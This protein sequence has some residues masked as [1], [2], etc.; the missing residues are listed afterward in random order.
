[1]RLEVGLLTAAGSPGAVS[2]DAALTHPPLAEPFPQSRPLP[3][4]RG[5]V[6]R[7]AVAG[8]LGRIES[9]VVALAAVGLFALYARAGRYW[10]DLIDEGY[11]LYLASRVAAGELPY[12]DFDTYYTPAVFYLY[13]ATFELFGVS[14]E[15]IRL[16]LAATRVAWFVLL[17]RLTRRVAPWPFAGLPFLVVAAVDAVPIAPEPHP[18]WFAML[19]T[20]VALDAIVRH[21]YKPRVR[22]VVAA[23][24]AAGVAF[25]FKQNVGA[26]TA[27]SVGA[28]L[29]LRERR[30]TGRLLLAGQG[31]FALVLAL[32]ATVLLWPGLD[33]RVAVTVWLPLLATLGLLVGSAWAR[34]RVDAWTTGLGP[35]LRDALAAGGAFVAVT[36]LWLVPLTL[37][38]GIDGTPFGLFVGAVNQ[39]ALILPLPSPPP[40]TRAV[41]LAAIWLPIA[42][43]ALLRR[44]G[45]R[46]S[47][48]IVV[49]ALVATALLPWLPIAETAPESLDDAPT[50]YPWVGS[51]DEQLGTLY[52]Y[53]PALGAWAGLAMLGVAGWRGAPVEPLAAYLLVGTLSL[54]AFYPRMDVAHAMFAG[55]PLLVVG[56]CGIA[57]AYR[58]LA[59]PA[60][61]LVRGLIFASLLLAPLAA[62]APHVSWRYA[63]LVHA[64]PRA[65]RPPAYVP[66]GLERADVLAPENVADS[67][68]G[69]VRFV[70]AGTPPGQPFFAYP[71]VPMF[72][73]LA[74][75]PN[76][77]RFDHVIPGALTPDDRQHMIRDLDTRKPRYVLWVHGG[78]VYWGTDPTDRDLSDYVWGCY[79]QVANFPPYLMLERRC[80]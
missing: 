70:Q 50:H 69:A 34:V 48:R 80:P 58:A 61:V 7:R 4:R 78:V 56:A 16:L 67:I 13:A 35:F 32:A 12:R 53:L 20:L 31:A 76:P 73:F 27:L 3:W 40:S 79:A 10:I 37:A 54:L 29:L 24:L 18:A 49:G 77:T 68:R 14:V 66:L 1:M 30:A 8:P 62:V 60:G 47:R 15:P 52:V 2:T 25:A 75:R 11:F 44:P 57:R 42:L 74:E 43:A 45:E 55:P 5:A 6:G 33:G 26:F 72:Y 28:Y 22:W 65:P 59:R 51:L 9:V 21:H 36:L 19:A 23:G 41:V 39:G 71:A 38:L 17:Y 46:P 64:D 63:T